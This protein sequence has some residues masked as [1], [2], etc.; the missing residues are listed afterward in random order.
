MFT[1]LIIFLYYSQSFSIIRTK[2]DD[3]EEAILREE[4]KNIDTVLKK[5]KKSV[6]LFFIF[7]NIILFLLLHTI[8]EFFNDT[9]IIVIKYVSLKSALYCDL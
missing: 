4:L 7:T 1:N 9:M 3:E 5:M 2:A 6:S 8:R